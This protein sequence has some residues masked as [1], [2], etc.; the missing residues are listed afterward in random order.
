M[1]LT[2]WPQRIDNVW[3][4]VESLIDQSSELKAIIL[5]LSEDEFPNRELPKR[6]LKQVQRGLS[7]HWTVGNLKSYKKLVPVLELYPNHDV[8]TFDDD[9]IYPKDVVSSLLRAS[10]NHPKTV[11]GMRGY[12]IAVS[13]EAI[14]P[15][16]YWKQLNFESFGKCILLTGVGGIL[17]PATLL[18]NELI[19]NMTLAS[20]LA[21]NADDLWF[22]L[23]T[24]KSN[25]T[26]YCLGSSDFRLNHYKLQSRALSI[27]NVEHGENDKQLKNILNHFPEVKAMLLSECK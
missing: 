15:Y 9:V 3:L 23:V 13:N 19:K 1:S 24:L 6:L 22:W 14:L 25:L 26:I 17:Y 18:S 8:I 7:I 11:V 10:E 4:T 2:T 12:K 16:A 27:R 5:V 21:P 20:K